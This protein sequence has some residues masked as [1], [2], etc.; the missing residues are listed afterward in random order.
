MNFTHFRSGLIALAVC[1][2]A[3]SQ[4][5]TLVSN[6]PNQVSGTQM[7]FAQVA[8]DFTLA[9]GGT[10]SISSIDFWS[11]QFS[12]ADYRG[13]IAWTIFNDDGLGGIGTVRWAGTAAIPGVATG[14]STAFGYDEYAF[15]IPVAINLTAGDHYWLGLHNGALSETDDTEMLWESSDDGQAPLGMYRDLANPGQGWIESDY[16]HAFRIIGVRDIDPNPGIP[17]PTTLAL[18]LGALVAAGAVRR[19]ARHAR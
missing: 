9:G 8:D 1:A 6:L 14:N 10:Y 13:S 15:S 11:I 5:A 4:A 18:L 7:S 19:Q 17:E 3:A 2:G 16:Q 12:A